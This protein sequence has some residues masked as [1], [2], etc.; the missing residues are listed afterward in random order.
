M[1]AYPHE[2]FAERRGL[3]VENDGEVGFPFRKSTPA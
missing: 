3:W 1:L 2:G